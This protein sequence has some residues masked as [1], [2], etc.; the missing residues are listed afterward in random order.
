MREL[1]GTDGGV[2]TSNAEFSSVL[3]MTVPTEVS[4]IYDVTVAN[5]GGNTRT[6]LITA[7]PISTK[8][9][10]SDGTMTLDNTGAKAPAANW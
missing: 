10:K 8:A 1:A 3:G 9:N 4:S 5:V 6:F 2:V 7:A